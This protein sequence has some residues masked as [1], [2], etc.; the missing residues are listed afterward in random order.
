MGIWTEGTDIYNEL[1]EVEETISKAL[2]TRQTI[3]SKGIEGLLK[4]GGKRLRPALVLLSGQF[5]Q[6]DGKNLCPL[7]RVSKSYMA[8]WFMM[9]L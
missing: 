8:T 9:I 1:M 4:A 2:K 5:G 3:L 7:Q 6:Y